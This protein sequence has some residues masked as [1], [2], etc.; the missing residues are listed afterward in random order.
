MAAD[1]DYTNSGKLSNSSIQTISILQKAVSNIIVGIL[2]VF[3]ASFAIAIFD[4]I[5]Y[6][7][8]FNPSIMK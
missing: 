4:A 6:V 1:F 3:Y 5:A 7:A 2:K 8:I